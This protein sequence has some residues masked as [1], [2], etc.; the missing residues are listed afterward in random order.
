MLEYSWIIPVLPVLSFV[1]I[2]FFTRWNEK[3][4]SGISIGAILIGLAHSIAILT[5]VL[6]NP[7][8]FEMSFK[9]IVL[10]NFNLEIGILIDPLTSVMLIVVCTVSSLVQIYSLGYMHGDP[11][12]SRY[13]SFLSLFTFSMLGLVLANNFAMIFIFWELVGLT[14]YLLI[15]FFYE[16]KSAADAGKKAFITT[17]IGDLG[18]IV[19]IL[20]LVTYAGTLNYGEVFELVENGHI[21]A[22]ILAAAGIFI[23]CGAI[24][25]SAQFPLHVW[26]PDAMEGPTPVSALIH[27]ATMV[28]AGVYLVA[29]CITIFAA[30]ESAAMVVATIGAITA[31]MAATI[32]L[33]QNDI[34]RV[35][36]YSTVSQLGYMIMAIGLGS[37]TA[38]IFHLMTHAFFKALLFL[39]AGS[40]IHAAHTQDIREMGGL[41][42]KM[43]ITSVTFIIGSLSLAGIFPLSGFWSKDEILASAHGYPIF[44]VVALAV[45]FMTA[46]YMT[47]LCFMTF[48]G[49][50]RVQEHYDHAH[51]SPKSM[52]YPLMILAF[53]AIF[54]GWVGM[55]WL[56]KGFGSFVY[57]HHPHHGHADYLLMIISTLVAGSGI[58]FG[59]LMYG[60]KVIS[61]D[62]MAERFKPIYNLLLNKYYFDEIYNA[63]II[64]PI[65]AFCRFLWSFDNAVIDGLVNLTAKF[66]L[67]LSTAHNIFDKYVVDGLVNGSG[68]TIWGIGSAIRQAQTGRVQNY[69]IVIF[70]G[71]VVAL[72][73]MLNVL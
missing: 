61:A 32:G 31:F 10:S 5:K 60:K 56:P 12:F 66:T 67:L 55:P 63:V 14:S 1:L 19:G 35:L 47:R 40:V 13:F 45:A 29:R 9:W 64:K 37:M 49:K 52:T 46:F 57:H 20:M 22:G 38:G 43:K 59:Y 15:G 16:K 36:A 54:A 39:G 2:I 18:F 34:K 11:R 51:E 28:A 24:G 44:M 72:I 26:L 42:N 48:F 73:I 50:P 17:R 65:L 25:K 71:L 69:A 6:A 33:V 30:S 68:Y 53:L 4:S 23:F 58:V 27:A 41:S 62:K 21:P 8:P 7:E 3:L 70:A